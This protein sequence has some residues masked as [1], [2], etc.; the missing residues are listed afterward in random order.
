MADEFRLQTKNDPLCGFFRWGSKL[1]RITNSHMCIVHGEVDRCLLGEALRQIVP[2]FELL[3]NLQ[4]NRGEGSADELVQ[5]IW[6]EHPV[7]FDNEGF[8]RDL[9]DGIASTEPAGLVRTPLRLLLV[10]AA[11]RSRTCVHL[12]ISH[13]V[14]DVKSGNIVL[15]RLIEEYGQLRAGGEKG[16]EVMCIYEHHPLPR[17]KPTWYKG[18]AE[19]VRRGRAQLEIGKR[20]MTWHRTQIRF[21]HRTRPSAQDANT[22]GNDFCHLVL[23]PALQEGIRAAA[24]HYGATINTLF[25]A[26][27]ARYIGRHQERGSPLAVY[28]VA[29][30]LRKLLGD[31]FAES[32]RSFMID[33]RLRIPHA[34][35]TRRLLHAIEAEMAAARGDRLELE[36]GRMESAISLFRNPLPKALVYWVMKRTQG[37]NLLYSNPGVVEEDFSTFGA[38]D[39]KVSDVVIFG[40]LV[41]PYDLMFVTPMVNG[42]LQLDVVYRKAHFPEIH[43]QFVEPFVQELQRI[44]DQVPKSGS[45]TPPH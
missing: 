3:K 8:R 34:A 28:T 36:V 29:V 5:E 7:A 25:S 33:C 24:R 30:S 12:G 40:C 4:P 45:D 37:T 32:F 42:K 35:D 22:A 21:G 41:P 10:H 27:L 14:A 31:S 39:L 15:A 2:K 9:M 17:L 43:H 23:P 6:T 19:I 13:D 16:R 38:A 1:F 18:A 26:A 20:M 11:D 44:V